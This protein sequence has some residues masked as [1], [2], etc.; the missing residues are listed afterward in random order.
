MPTLANESGM[1][2]NP[3]DR[4]PGV[5]DSYPDLLREASQRAVPEKSKDKDQGIDR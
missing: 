1:E 5:K 4:M 3:T 2:R